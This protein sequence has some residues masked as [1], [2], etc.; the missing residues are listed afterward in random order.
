MKEKLRINMLEFTRPNKPK[1]FSVE[2]VA[3]QLWKN[4]SK[5]LSTTGAGNKISKEGFKEYLRAYYKEQ[6]DKGLNE[7]SAMK[8]A[9][10]SYNLS[11]RYIS[12]EERLKS[13]TLK[14]FFGDNI[15]NRRTFQALTKKKG[16]FTKFDPLKVKYKESGYIL[17]EGKKRHY[18]IETYEEIAI[19]TWQS[20]EEKI[21]L[22]SINE[23]YD[24]LEEL[25]EY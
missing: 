15:E 1:E 19:I 21:V 22:N 10:K 16:R 2:N 8:K 25:E 20:P 11:N 5:D 7:K 17:Q 9:I 23:A 12:P 18:T 3:N 24:Y 4:F 14:D 6:L 13:F